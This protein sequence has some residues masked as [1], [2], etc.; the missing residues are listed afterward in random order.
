MK[1]R[2][3]GVVGNKA[4]MYRSR[5][6]R[7]RVGAM[8]AGRGGRWIG[9]QGAVRV[10]TGRMG[11]TWVM[12]VMAFFEVGRGGNVVT[13][14][15]GRWMEAE[16]FRIEWGLRYD[17]LTAVMLVVVCTVSTLVHMYSISYMEADPHRPRFMAYLS[18]FT[19]FMRVLVT[20]DNY[21]QMF[22]SFD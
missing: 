11:V 5:L 17:A 19:F 13:R 8:R 20:A 15:L 22:V 18:L 12:S 16:G 4:T 10:T 3:R 2:W 7:P 6:R 9:E 1:G 21:V 14:K